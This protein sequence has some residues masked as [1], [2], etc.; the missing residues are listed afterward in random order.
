LQVA[1]QPAAVPI[2]GSERLEISSPPATQIRSVVVYPGRQA[3]SFVD[4]TDSSGHLALTVPVPDTLPVGD[5]LRIVVRATLLGGSV[6]VVRSVPLL[7]PARIPLAAALSVE[8]PPA[9]F[10]P[11]EHA[12][13]LVHFSPHVRVQVRVS[14]P[15]ASPIS[16]S[17][18]TDGMGDL[19]LTV[20]VP[21]QA[22]RQGGGG[23]ALL[24]VRALDLHGPVEVARTVPIEQGIEGP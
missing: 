20:A 6:Q 19:P 11:G 18:E 7:P 13:L 10:Q 9:G 15:G 24:I 17:G 5:S 22:G 3:V 4:S 23:T 8:P 12:P 21:V 1:V 14:F 2:G 16:L